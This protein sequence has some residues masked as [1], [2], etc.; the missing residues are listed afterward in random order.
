MDTTTS[1]L[2]VLVKR[3]VLVEDKCMGFSADHAAFL[4]NAWAAPFN[5]STLA[6]NYLYCIRF[7]DSTSVT[8]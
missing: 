8:Y 5:S 3:D 2:P 7:A 1:E 4:A 6:K